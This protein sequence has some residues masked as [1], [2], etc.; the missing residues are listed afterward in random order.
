MNKTKQSKK[1]SAPADK[2]AQA[3]NN[4]AF[5][6]YISTDPLATSHI[7]QIEAE[8]DALREQTRELLAAANTAYT[9]LFFAIA[10]AERA[11]K[12]N[13]TSVF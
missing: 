9:Q 6:T 1:A 2:S 12:A 3:A 7:K 4:K 11:G 10:K 8:R 13:S 5:A